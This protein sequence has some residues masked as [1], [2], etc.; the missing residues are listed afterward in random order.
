MVAFVTRRVLAVA[1][2]G[3][4]WTWVLFLV[5]SA[6]IVLLSWKS[7]HN[8]R[9]HGFYRFFAFEAILALILLNIEYWFHQPFS[10]RQILSWL[11]L[12]L[13]LLLAV[14]GFML[15]RRIGKPDAAIQDPIRLSIEKTTQLVKVGAY[16]YIRHPLYASLLCLAWGAFLKHPSPVGAGLGAIAT[17]A[18]YATSRMEEAENLKHFGAEYTDYMQQTKMFIPYVF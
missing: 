13:S 6:G 5:F 15:L 8:W 10:V 14:H 7:L 9:S 12:L 1:I 11:L 4:T 3:L 17:L 18:L 2:D 16:H